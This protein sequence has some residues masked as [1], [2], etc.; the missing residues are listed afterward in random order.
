MDPHPSG[1]HH[2]PVP[3]PLPVLSN[4]GKLEELK[5]EALAAAAQALSP[6]LTDE[7][8]AA[9]AEPHPEPNTDPAKS[10]QKKLLEGKI[11]EALR[12][13]YDPEIPVNIYDL[14]LIYEIDV[15]DDDSVKVKMTLT[16]PACPVAGTLP[17][18]VEKKV[19]AVPEVK[20]AEVE[21]VWDPPWSRD[22]M[23]EAALLQLGMF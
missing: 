13:I 18:E 6:V 1:Q 16:A 9:A 7:S 2:I 15:K 3:R 22:R 14:G 21:L 19:N 11:I 4:S 12:Q 20:A 10:I 5:Q 17:G 23:S 8:P